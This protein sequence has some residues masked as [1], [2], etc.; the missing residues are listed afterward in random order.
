MR[1][2][3]Q[4]QQNKFLSYLIQLNGIKIGKIVYYSTIQEEQHFKTIDERNLYLLKKEDL[5]ELLNY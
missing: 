3:Q 2:F 4:Q 5:K 1:I